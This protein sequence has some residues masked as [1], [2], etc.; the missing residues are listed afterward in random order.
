MDSAYGYIA[1]AM[2]VHINVACMPVRYIYIHIGP[3]MHAYATY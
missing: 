3:V 1:I 2:A